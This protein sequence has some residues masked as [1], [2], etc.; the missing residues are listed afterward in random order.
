MGELITPREKFI[1]ALEGKQPPG[2]VPHFELVFFLTMEAFGKV[3]PTQRVFGQWNQMSETER[4]LHR[5]DIAE[6]YVMTARHYDH[7]A[8]FFQGGNT[9]GNQRHAETMKGLDCIRDISGD[10]YF[11]MIH[12]DATYAIPDGNGL[13]EFT[14]EI[15]DHPDKVKDNAKR[16]VEL[17]LTNAAELKKHGALDGVLKS[18]LLSV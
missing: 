14:M 8:I 13:V 3:H 6:T 7:S 4:Q 11:L 2:R 16:K 18:K 5:R 12:G 1:M 9:W 17:A 15:A 10:D